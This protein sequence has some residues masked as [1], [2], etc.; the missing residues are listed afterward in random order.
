V[1]VASFYIDKYEV[2][3]EQYA[4][5]MRAKNYARAPAGWDG[6]NYPP[7]SARHPVTG[8]TWDDANAYA[9][10]KGKRL[11]TEEEWEFAARGTDG[12]RYPWGG[13]WRAGVANADAE[14]QARKRTAEVGQFEGGASPFGILDMAGNAWE[15]TATPL[16]AYPGGRL[17]PQQPGDIRVI[18]GGYWGSGK[19][20]ISATFRG[21]LARDDTKN[22]TNTGFRCAMDTP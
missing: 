15:W 11:P 8:V 3:C 12:R 5:F 17:P 18:R 21:G 7:G 14:G 6:P 1:K 9:Q 10:W 16:A 19:E 4:E 2:T 20:V 13:D 22:N